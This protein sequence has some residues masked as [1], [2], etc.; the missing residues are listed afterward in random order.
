[1]AK[2]S[3]SAPYRLCDRQAVDYLGSHTT[4][5]LAAIPTAANT[6]IA[7]R[8]RFPHEARIKEAVKGSG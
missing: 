1:M 3:F 6:P 2:A 4:L 5:G 8:E 7:A